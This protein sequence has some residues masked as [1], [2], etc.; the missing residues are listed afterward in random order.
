MQKAPGAVSSRASYAISQDDFFTRVTIRSQE[1]TFIENFHREI[2]DI[3]ISEGN[4]ACYL[5]VS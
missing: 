2:S 1:K 5:P 3:E 4:R